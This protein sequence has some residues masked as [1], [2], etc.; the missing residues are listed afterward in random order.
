MNGLSF[1]DIVEDDVIMYEDIDKAF[2]FISRVITTN[3]Y[4]L[5][6]SESATLPS[7]NPGLQVHDLEIIYTTGNYKLEPKQWIWKMD[8]IILHNFGDVDS[9]DFKKDYPQCFI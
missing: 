1:F 3:L 6:K 9:K 8:T 2:K 4:E 5:S 7:A